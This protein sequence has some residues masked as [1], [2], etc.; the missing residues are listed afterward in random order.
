MVT[1]TQA[2]LLGRPNPVNKELE[3][4]INAPCRYNK[5]SEVSNLQSK[6]QLLGLAVSQYIAAKTLMKKQN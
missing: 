1:R 5:E 2:L 3:I 4:K 6:I